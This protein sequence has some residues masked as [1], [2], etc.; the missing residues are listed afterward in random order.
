MVVIS[1]SIT[2]ASEQLV[3]GFPKSL[4]LAANVSST[5]FYTTDGTTP[6]TFS[7]IY[8][9]AIILPTD[10]LEFVLKA[11]ASNGTDTSPIITHT[12]STD[13]IHNARLPH[14]TISPAS[15]NAP[16]SLFP[17]G[18]NSPQPHIN[19]LNNSN[20]GTTVLNP[21]LP[22]I[23]Y[24]Y[25]AQGNSVGA[26][27]PIDSYLQVYTTT[28]KEGRAGAGIGNLPGNVE[29]IGRRSPLEYSPEESSRSDRIFHS[30]AMVIFQDSSTEDP[31]DP[32]MINRQAFSL[33]NLEITKDGASL[34]PVGLETQSTTGSFI[35]SFYNERTQMLTSYYRDSA[36]N[37][38]I[39][40]TAPYEFK[41]TAPTNL[42]GMVFS[43]YDQGVGRVYSWGFG[44]YRV[45][46]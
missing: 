46:T 17:F 11:F 10:T 1:V 16:Y 15:S 42:S 4:T 5:I 23:P 45:L 33:E 40:S 6:D 43:K 29:V 9:S 26:N 28:D 31:S 44:R 36:T 27:Q 41:S 37:R 7:S 21:S 22:V 19:Y 25:D 2:E 32:P 14:S 18:S 34:R 38:W 20:A 3:A 24:G 39:I 12:Y 30:K 13:I 8:T 35:R